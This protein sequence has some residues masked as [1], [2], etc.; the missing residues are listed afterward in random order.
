MAAVESAKA[1]AVALAYSDGNR[2]PTFG[3]WPVSLADDLESFLA[4]GDRKV[5]LFAQQHN[6]QKVDFP[7]AELNGMP[8]DPFFNVNT[9]QDFADAEKMIGELT[10]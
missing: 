2:H 8:F 9:P 1:P 6:L 4:N 5:M 10:E 7:L 3:L